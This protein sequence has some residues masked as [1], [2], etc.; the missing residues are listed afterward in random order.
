VFDE[1]FLMPC[2][3]HMFG[4]KM[5]S[6]EHRLAM[7]EIAC[8]VDARI[9]PFEF[10]IKRELRGETYQTVK[11][12]LEEQFAKDQYDF[13]WI[14]GMDNANEFHKW[15][16]YEYLEKMIRFVVVPRDG[17]ERDPKVDWYLKPPHIFLGHTDG[18]IGE[19]S[20][21]Q[22]RQLLQDRHSETMHGRWSM[23]TARELV[24]EKVFAYISEHQLYQEK[25]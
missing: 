21:T 4:K 24:D 16:N 1:V 7:L 22:V 20:S 14:I 5:V 18:K 13:S 23:E 15:V 8:R 2:Y 3:Q 12:L 6:A 9:K 19:M 11:L 10:E 17:V 25:I